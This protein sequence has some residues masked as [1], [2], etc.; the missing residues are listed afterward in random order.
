MLAKEM[1]SRLSKPGA[2]MAFAFLSDRGQEGYDYDYGGSPGAAAAKPLAILDHLGGSPLI[3][4][5]GSTTIRR[6]VISAS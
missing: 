3:A 5:A 1:T 4:V 6:R 2:G